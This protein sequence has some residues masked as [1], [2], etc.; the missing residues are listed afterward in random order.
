MEHPILGEQM[1]VPFPKKLIQTEISFQ[2]P[3][4]KSEETENKIK[5]AK[6]LA[7]EEI[8]KIN[9]NYTIAFEKGTRPLVFDYTDIQQYILEKF[10]ENENGKNIPEIFL[11]KKI[12]AFFGRKTDWVILIKNLSPKVLSRMGD[13]VNK[14]E[15][16]CFEAAQQLSS[17]S[18][19]EQEL[20]AKIIAGKSKGEALYKIMVLKKAIDYIEEFLH[21]KV[22]MK[23]DLD[24]S[25]ITGE[26]KNLRPSKKPFELPEEIWLAFIENSVK[27]LAPMLSAKEQSSPSEVQ[28]KEEPWPD[29]MVRR[30]IRRK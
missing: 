6:S 21:K 24:I 27:S 12:G 28:E 5:K 10:K 16:I 2:Y 15:K 3:L 8:Q 1:E 11:L 13:S 30:N 18:Q 19:K 29:F 4:K 9:R 7:P 20:I 14:E 22:K 23:N 17:F 26:L 25:K